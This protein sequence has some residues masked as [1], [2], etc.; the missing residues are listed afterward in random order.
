MV[1]LDRRRRSGRRRGGHRGA[2][3]RRRGRDRET[4]RRQPRQDRSHPAVA[5]MTGRGMLASALVAFAAGGCTITES[6]TQVMLEIDA[7]DTVR[8]RLETLQ[9][10]IAVTEDD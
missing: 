3:H 1:V 2:R 6:R 10:L 8:L 4:D 9:I 7:D 5:A